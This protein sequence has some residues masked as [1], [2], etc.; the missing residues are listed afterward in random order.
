VSW[1]GGTTTTSTTGVY[2]LSSVTAGSQN[3]TA[4]A[5][6]YLPRT[7][8]ASVTS[9]ATTTLNVAIATAGKIA[10]KVTGSTGAAVA[11]ATITV[12]GGVVATS[13]TGTTGSTGIFTTNWIP[14]GSYTITASQ[15][16]HTTQTR[17]ASVTS[18]VTTNV[19]ITA[20]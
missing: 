12:K 11:G 17:T 3:I 10:I 4:S 20:F 18:G 8:A 15:T 6:G 1:S 13:V 2:T 5:P 16:G 14:V 7:L 19:A 9:G